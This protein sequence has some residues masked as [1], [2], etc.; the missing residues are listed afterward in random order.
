V[1]EGGIRVVHMVYSELHV[2]FLMR[3]KYVRFKLNG[4]TLILCPRGIVLELM[5]SFLEWKTCVEL[6][7]LRHYLKPI[8]R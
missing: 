1:H 4:F 2:D 5:S 3:V 6:K 8:I 7:E